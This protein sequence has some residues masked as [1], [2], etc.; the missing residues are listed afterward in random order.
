[1]LQSCVI[2]PAMMAEYGQSISFDYTLT[3]VAGQGVIA[4]NN[5]ET[6]YCGSAQLLQNQKIKFIPQ[7]ASGTVVY[8]AHNQKY[9]GCLIIQDEIKPESLAVINRLSNSSSQMIMLTGDNENVA[10]NIASNLGLSSY[11]ANLL[12]QDKLSVIEDLFL[13]KKP[14]DVLCFIGDGM[15]DTPSLVRADVGITMGGLGS[16]AAMEAADIVLM[17]DDL[18]GLLTAKNLAQRTMRVVKQN[19]I[20]SILV[21]ISILTMSAL[22][23]ANMWLAIFGDVGVALLTILNAFRVKHKRKQI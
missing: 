2:N 15:N 5:A 11:R 13:E 8:V 3:N 19:I 18:R 14:K 21:K 10:S 6:I 22:G 23:F 9:V 7:E 1:M 17:H 4:T 16:D 12:P 20:F